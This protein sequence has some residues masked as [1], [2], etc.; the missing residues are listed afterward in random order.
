MIKPLLNSLLVQECAAAEFEVI[1]V[2][3]YPN[4]PLQLEYPRFT[5]FYLPD[6]SISKKRNAGTRIARG[7][8]FAFIDDDCIAAVDWVGTGSAY[9]DR[10]PETA[11]VEGR[12]VIASTAPAAKAA[13]REYRRLEKNGY[14]T[15]N[16]FIRA[17]DFRNAGGF[18]E[19]F[20][21]QR[22]DIDLCFTVL[23]QG[24]TIDFCSDIRVTHR[25]R[26]GEP[27]DL[28]KNCRNRR[29]DP[30]LFEKHPELYLKHA[31]SPLPP[32][33]I[34]IL[35]LHALTMLAFQKKRFLLPAAAIN[36]MA[37]ML[38]GI[39]RTGFRPFSF[40]TWGVETLQLA[41]APLVVLGALAYGALTLC[42]RKQ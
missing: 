22:E 18:D 40:K 42:I 29:F 28:L 31:G 9:L 25:F 8:T 33:Q 7:S 4:G 39:R 34:I 6:L 32:T 20:T 12:T 11:A 30:L 35:L 2:S 13:L 1:I 15:N 10:H 17:G 38:L 27:W 24:G 14:R 3:D 5:W 23:E 16:L 37:C 19:R 41:A 26:S 21:V 36:L